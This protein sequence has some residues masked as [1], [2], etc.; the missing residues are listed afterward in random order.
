MRERNPLTLLF[1]TL[2]VLVGM[3]ANSLLAR[4]ALVGHLIGPTCFT[5]VRLA[6][7]ALVLAVISRVRGGQTRPPQITA[8]WLFL[9]A[10]AFSYTYVVLGA[11]TGALLLFFAVQFTMLA[12]AVRRGEPIKRAHV[13]GALMALVGLYVLVAARLH[14]PALWAVGGMLIAGIAWGFYSIQG[15]KTTAP[16]AYTASNFM[17]AAVAA[18]LVLGVRLLVNTQA[19]LPHLKGLMEAALSGSVTSAFVYLVWYAILPSLTTIAA[20]TVQ[21]T[22]PIIV[23]LGGWLIL[24]EHLTLRLVVAGS[25]VLGGVALAMKKA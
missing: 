13:L 23:A 22:I 19:T 2:A 1:T 17:Y 4:A 3:A 14:R 18:G 15:R 5:F 24:G 9:Y 6:S 7:G 25:L 10:A 11:A 8:I 16:L 12:Y 20:G 21:L